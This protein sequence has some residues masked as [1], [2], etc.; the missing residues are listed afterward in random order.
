M[1]PAYGLGETRRA[2]VKGK[3]DGWREEHDAV[4]AL[5][6]QVLF[7]IMKR[8]QHAFLL[9]ARAWGLIS[10]CSAAKQR[11]KAVPMR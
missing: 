9:P 1:Y 8:S 5:I 7:S 3:A 10:L 4:I 6:C 2:N 11:L